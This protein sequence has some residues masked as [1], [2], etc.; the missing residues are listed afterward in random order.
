MGQQQVVRV[1]R[2]ARTGTRLAHDS[3]SAPSLLECHGLHQQPRACLPCCLEPLRI[4]RHRPDRRSLTWARWSHP[5]WGH[6]RRCRQS[7]TPTSSLNDSDGTPSLQAP[8]ALQ[9]EGE[10]ALAVATTPS[11]RFR[12]TAQALLEACKAPHTASTKNKEVSSGWHLL[13][14]TRCCKTSLENIYSGFGHLALAARLIKPR[15]AGV[16]AARRSSRP[17]RMTGC[18]WPPRAGVDTSDGLQSAT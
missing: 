9:R 8:L 7:R 5:V 12:I 11:L 6:R 17:A 13:V 1:L 10:N 14:R 2:P 4:S 18:I 3:R 16:L 15:R